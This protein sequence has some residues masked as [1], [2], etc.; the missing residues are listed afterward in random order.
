MLTAEQKSNIMPIAKSSDT[1]WAQGGKSQSNISSRSSL[2][3]NE[4]PPSNDINGDRHRLGISNENSF[5]EHPFPSSIKQ[6]SLQKQPSHLGSTDSV[7]VESTATE[8]I[9]WIQQKCGEIVDDERTQLFILILISLNSI[10]YGA[11][12]YPEVKASPVAVKGFE[13]VDMIILVIFTIESLLQIAFNGFRRF[14]KDGWLVFDLI[15]V[16][17]SWLSVEIDDLRAFRVFRAFK[18]VTRV[19]SLRKVV[20]ALFSIIPAITAIFT[21]LLL[22]FFIFAVMFTTLFKDFYEEGYTQADYFGRL[23]LTLFTLFQ[24]LCLDEWSGIAYEVTA[25]HMWAWAIFIVFIV[26]SA[27]VVINLLIAVICDALQILRTAEE[28]MS[29]EQELAEK[30]AKYEEETTKIRDEGESVSRE[31]IQQKCNEMQQMLDQMIIAQESM[32]RT[33]Q[34]LSIALYAERKPDELMNITENMADESMEGFGGSRN[35]HSS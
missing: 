16:M 10:M 24:L 28:A 14:F 1:T 3:S 21:L 34:Y 22:I 20:V 7:E 26:M 13:T 19:S 5:E 15:I 23:D 2:Y 9:S 18:L 30:K 29:E 17:I 11:E 35:G 32:S 25:V 12:T 27:F 6:P 8:R 33:I 31:K 4:A